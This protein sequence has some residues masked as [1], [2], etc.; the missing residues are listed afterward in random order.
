MSVYSN[1]N[2]QMVD[3]IRV[4]KT[5]MVKDEYDNLKYIV[6]ELEKEANDKS[7]VRFYKATA[8]FRLTRVSLGSKENQKFMETHTDILRALYKANINFIEVIANVLKPEP[9]GLIYLYGVQSVGNSEEE[10]TRKCECDFQVLLASFQGTHRTSHITGVTNEIMNF[11]FKNLKRQKFV[12]VVKGVPSSKSGSG[13]SRNPLNLDVSTDEQL[14]QFLSASDQ[15]EFCLVLMATPINAK[16]LTHW[17]SKS[18]EEA[19]KWE[20]QKQ[21]SSQ[22][23]L[24]VGIPL[25]VSQNVST[26]T[27]QNTGS[28][29]NKGTSH[30]ISHNDG[31]SHNEGASTN[32]SHTEGGGHTTGTSW[33]EGQNSSA[34]HGTNESNSNSN[35]WNVGVNGSIGN[36]ALGQLGASGGIGGSNSNTI[37]SSDTTTNGTSSSNGGSE[38]DNSTWSDA[39]SE[40]KTISD[41]TTSTDG[42]TN[43]STDSKGQTFSQGTTKNTSTG[44]STG[45]NLGFNMSK[46]YQWVDKT[47]EYICQLLEQQNTR[48]KQMSNGDGG[49]FV[50]MYIATDTPK[51]QKALEGAAQVTWVNANAMIDMLR[52]ETPSSADQK[53]LGMHLVALSPCMEVVYNPKNNSGY[54][55]KYSSCL[56]SKELA[57]YCHPPRIS[58]GGLDNSTEDLPQNFAVPTDRQKNEIMI[59][60]V[61]AP[62]RYSYEMALKT[63]NGYATTFKY[64]ISQGEMHH[65]FIS[66]ASRSGKSV[67]AT[68]AVL[69]MYNKA[70][71]TDRY[72]NK[73]HK[74]VLVLDPKG[75]WRRVGALLPKG[76]FKF[77]SVGKPNFHPLHMNLL[78]VP[79]NVQPYNYYNMVVSHFCSAY[80]L[81]DR[82]IAQISSIIYDLYEKNDVFGHEDDPDWANEHSKNITLEDVY[83]EI[84]KQLK[85]AIA[86]RNQHDA[87]ALQTYLTRLDMYHRKHSCEYVMFCNRG[88][89]SADILLGKDDFTVVE[90][91][92]LSEKSMRF[93][94]ILLMNSIYECALAGGPE[95]FYTNS[96]ET[97]IVLE[98]ANSVLIAGGQDDTAGQASIQ[99]FNEIIDKSASLGLFIWT[100]TQKIA[101]MPKS[102]IAN[103][104]IIFIGRTA[105]GEDVQ[106]VDSA[107]GFDVHKNPEMHRFYPRMTTGMFIA[108]C[109]KGRTLQ[110]QTPVLVQ[111]AMLKSTIPTDEELDMIIKEN[112]MERMLNVPEKKAW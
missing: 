6:N 105:Q 79:K 22:L 83:I 66:G 10:A 67:L 59:G 92:G 24:S 56:A 25:T 34:S 109:S 16:Y 35:S 11:V 32:T 68:R 12:S 20:R 14:E 3:K 7:V 21:G 104:G 38:S 110:S 5:Y 57:G 54:Y 101:S 80:G 86:S 49:F 18:L 60:H 39:T 17:L 29:S 36:K 102:V 9:Y 46:S 52:L 90:S 27:S 23:G 43:G 62:T 63:G 87:E 82:A 91:N 2:A 19:S 8:F 31:I 89:E 41:G 99:R 55:Y 78:R 73:K 75:E 42:W 106:V 40:G 103:S 26:G 97:V 108:K 13:D 37:G 71:Y 98:E 48:L 96:Y 100:I 50:D 45:M 85:N 33:N 1:Y 70:L 112:E 77:Y 72:G 93:F 65:A 69:E 28:S 30:N 4:I 15:I 76:S 51:H 107:I 88:G 64:S 94:F 95:G 111:A 47:V 53:N 58:I 81:L 74:R 44:M 84:E 61:I